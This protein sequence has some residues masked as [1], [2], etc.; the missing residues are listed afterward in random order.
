VCLSIPARILA[1]DEKSGVSLPARVSVA[2]VE[3]SV[4][5]GL[6]P[7]ASVGDFVVTHA[8]FAISIIPRER[9]AETI[10]MLGLDD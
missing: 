2:G 6:V 3:R 9:A 1:I 4:D 7:E 8:G 10:E 5:L